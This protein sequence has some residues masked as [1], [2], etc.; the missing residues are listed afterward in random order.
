MVRVTVSD[1]DADATTVSGLAVV[2]GLAMGADTAGSAIT[3]SDTAVSAVVAKALA[4]AMASAVRM[5]PD[6]KSVS[7]TLGGLV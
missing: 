1:P 4:G 5:G 7:C 2:M 6:R 3:A